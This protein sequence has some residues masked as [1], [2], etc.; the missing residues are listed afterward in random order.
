MK[1]TYKILIIIVFILIIGNSLYLFRWT[2]D[3]LRGYWI[4]NVVGIIIMLMVNWLM[5]EK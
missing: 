4:G 2:G 5:K 3:M 1:T